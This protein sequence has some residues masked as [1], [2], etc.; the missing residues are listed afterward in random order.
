MSTFLLLRELILFSTPAFSS[1][2][3]HAI[4][5]GLVLLLN[6]WFIPHSSFSFRHFPDLFFLTSFYS[7]S[8][9][10][11]SL[12]LSLSFFGIRVLQ[13]FYSCFTVAKW[14]CYIVLCQV[15]SHAHSRH[16]MRLNLVLTSRH[17][18]G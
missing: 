5:K 1:C 2:F 8:I 15:H 17:L 9:L 13:F 18:G 6:L 10:S 11:F 12:S 3:I 16:S 4:F 7:A 14:F